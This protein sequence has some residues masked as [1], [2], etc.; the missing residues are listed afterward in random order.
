MKKFKGTIENE[1]GLTFTLKD[2]EK[3]DNWIEEKF[4]EETDLYG[5]R[6]FRGSDEEFYERLSGTIDELDLLVIDSCFREGNVMWFETAQ[7]YEPE[8]IEGVRIAGI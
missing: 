1:V 3:V 8:E 2:V 7:E 5:I 4:P 6:D